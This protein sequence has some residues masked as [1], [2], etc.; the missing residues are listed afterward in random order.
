MKINFIGMN[1]KL[2]HLV[3]FLFCA[4]LGGCAFFGKP[5]ASAEVTPP[6]DYEYLIGPG[7]VLNV[8][9]W[10]NPE[11]SAQNVPVRPDGKISTPLVEDV[12]ASG[13]T[14]KQL[15]QDVTK[16][17]ATFI[18]DPIVTVT[19]TNFV[20]R[21]DEQVRVVGEAVNPTALPYRKN[22]SLLDVIIQVGG[23][24]EF[25]SGNSA[26]VVRKVGNEKREMAVR[27]EDLVVDGD[28]SANIP[29]FPGDV[30]IIPEAWF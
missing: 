16:A 11:V 20:G 23:L 3:I 15:S 22:M 1:N 9:V 30:L 4:S 6:Q 19:V 10:R 2:K 12:V 29:M 24:T 8:Y 21:Y 28:I 25:A 14:A 27:L 7:D 18:Q 17:L 13:K 5:P 26:K